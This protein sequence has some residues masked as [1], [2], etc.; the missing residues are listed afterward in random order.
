MI[1]KHTTLGEIATLLRQLPWGTRIHMGANKP[2][3][4]TIIIRPSM[5]DM[6]GDVGET[7]MH[8]RDLPALLEAAYS[9]HAAQ[10]LGV[11]GERGRD[12]RLSSQGHRDACPNGCENCDPLLRMVR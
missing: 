1:T 11:A 9:T 6:L 7:V 2:G 5:D 12:P 10:L 3:D 4:F 8:G